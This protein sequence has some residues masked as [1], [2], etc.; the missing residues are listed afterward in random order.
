MLGRLFKIGAGLLAMSGIYIGT[1]GQS[2]LN[3][4]NQ[5]LCDLVNSLSPYTFEGCKIQVWIATL[6]GVLAAVALVYLVFVG[7]WGIVRLLRRAWHTRSPPPLETP[8]NLADKAD[9]VARRIHGLAAKYP[10]VMPHDSAYSGHQTNDLTNALYMREYQENIATDVRGVLADADRVE[11]LDHAD[12]IYARNAV[13]A[14]RGVEKI[15]GVLA[16]IA[17]NVRAGGRRPLPPGEFE[18][19][20]SGD[21]YLEGK[22]SGGSGAEGPGG[23]AELTAARDMIIGP[24]AE[25]KGGDDG[26]GGPGGPLSVRAGDV[27]RPTVAAKWINMRDAFVLICEMLGLDDVSDPR[28]DRRDRLW[29]EIRQKARDSDIIIRG[30]PMP[31][32]GFHDSAPMEDIAR[33]H[34]RDF[35]FEPT[36][37]MPGTEDNEVTFG[38]TI[39]QNTARNYMT[40]DRYYDLHA[41]ANQLTRM[42]WNG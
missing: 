26:A 40:F 23:P 37:Y 6:W 3:T 16:R 4:T 5:N 19:E 28:A 1:V 31:A 36:R 35:D 17:S 27:R 42:Q 13:I 11:M 7:I 18:T 24:G 38:Q 39:R 12:G 22:V 30:R 8:A 29:P 33:E 21:P 34:W 14:R 10:Q 2:G 25:L 9:S 32:G 20:P 15:A 41:D